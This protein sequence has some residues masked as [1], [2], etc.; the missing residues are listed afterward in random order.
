MNFLITI[1]VRGTKNQ[2]ADVFTVSTMKGATSYQL[3]DEIHEAI[4]KR[5]SDLG[6][7]YKDLSILSISIC[8][9]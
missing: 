8:K 7:N 5:I 4:N 6:E 1:L 2:F 9:I 3:R